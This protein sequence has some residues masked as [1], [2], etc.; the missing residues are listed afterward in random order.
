MTNKIRKMIVRRQI[1]NVLALLDEGFEGDA[2][3]YT[4]DKQFSPAEWGMILIIDKQR[5]IARDH[6]SWGY[7]EEHKRKMVDRLVEKIMKR[8]AKKCKRSVN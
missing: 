8:R 7:A 4:V 3:Q 6:L 5:Q 1:E 2:L